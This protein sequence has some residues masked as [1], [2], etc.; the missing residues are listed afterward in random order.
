MSIAFSVHSYFPL[1]EN[2]Q[3]G[4]LQ[5]REEKGV[6]I[7][8]NQQRQSKKA[9]LAGTTWHRRRAKFSDWSVRTANE[10]PPPQL[11]PSAVVFERFDYRKAAVKPEPLAVGGKHQVKLVN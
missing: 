4:V 8:F 9:R 5:A 7:T 1:A 11:L 6:V 3:N 2:K 10:K